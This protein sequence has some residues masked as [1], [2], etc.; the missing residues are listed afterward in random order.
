M[1]TFAFV[2]SFTVLEIKHI[3]LLFLQILRLSEND[4]FGI[5]EMAFIGLDTLYEL[6]ISHNLLTT[7]PSLVGL[8]STLQSLDLSWNRIISFGNSYFHLC[9]N[10]ANVFS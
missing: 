9:I 4:I 10:I 2:G 6:D 5:H 3:F 7:D 8:I 1:H